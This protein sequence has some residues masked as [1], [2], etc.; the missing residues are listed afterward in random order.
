[1]SALLISVE[2]NVEQNTDISLIVNEKQ[3]NEA[4]KKGVFR[5]LTH[6]ITERL[7]YPG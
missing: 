6:R 3:P 2:H 4:M 7:P 1:M 5:T